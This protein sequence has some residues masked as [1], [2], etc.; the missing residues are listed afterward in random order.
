MKKENV[1]RAERDGVTKAIFVKKG[2][3]PRGRC[4]I[5]EFA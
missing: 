4:A 2:R 3:Q 5:M 1:L